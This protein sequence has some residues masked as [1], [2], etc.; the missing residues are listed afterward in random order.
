MQ[1]AKYLKKRAETKHPSRVKSRCSR[2]GESKI[3]L[4]VDLAVVIWI[5]CSVLAGFFVL[6]LIN[7]GP[8]NRSKQFFKKKNKINA[9]LAH[10]KFPGHGKITN[11]EI[12][13]LAYQALTHVSHVT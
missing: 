11:S 4:T 1:I 2:A 12:Q 6:N 13:P 5:I 9:F 7:S 3:E 8:D 10:R